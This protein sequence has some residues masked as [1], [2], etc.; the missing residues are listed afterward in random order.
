MLGTSTGTGSAAVDALR[1]DAALYR[2]VLEH[3]RRSH[4][5]ST[6]L[7]AS[8]KDVEAHVLVVTLCRCLRSQRAGALQHAL[9]TWSSACMLSTLQRSIEQMRCERAARMEAEAQLELAKESEK[10]LLSRWQ[11]EKEEEAALAATVTRGSEAHGQ[12]IQRAYRRPLSQLQSGP[13]R[14]TCSDQATIPVS[15][16][17]R[18]QGFGKRAESLVAAWHR[19][20]SGGPRQME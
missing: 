19:E 15:A 4:C 13:V 11:T 12:G 1:R 18:T 14:T 5:E 16:S 6:V 7:V 2:V 3:W 17:K 20:S 8:L 10:E 9:R